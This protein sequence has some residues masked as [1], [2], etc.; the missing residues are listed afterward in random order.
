[1]MMTENTAEVHATDTQIGQTIKS[2][3]VTDIPFHGRSYI[4]LL[5]VQ[6]R[7]EEL[8]FNS[9]SLGRN[10]S[11]TPQGNSTFDLYNAISRTGGGFTPSRGWRL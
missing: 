7:V 10:A 2:R 5:T 3:Q 6:A 1:M 11:S 8:F 4:D 9:S